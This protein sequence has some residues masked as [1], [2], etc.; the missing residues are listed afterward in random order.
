MALGSRKWDRRFDA[1]VI[2]AVFS[3]T[4]T[5]AWVFWP[6]ASGSR[7]AA[8]RLGKPPLVV[9]CA[10]DSVYSGEILRAFEEQTGIPVEP[11]YDTEA[12]KSL[13][14][15][16][17]IVV[18]RTH[19]RCDVFWNN[20]PLAMMQLRR[21]GLLVPYQGSGHQRIPAKYKDPDG[22]WTGFAARLRVQA[23]SNKFH[24]SSAKFVD[25]TEREDLSR[26]AVAKPLYGTTLMHY[27]LLWKIWGP[28]RLKKWHH[29]IRRRGAREVAGNGPAMDLVASGECDF[30]WT[31]TDD[32]F[33]AHDDGKPVWMQPVQ[34]TVPGKGSGAKP[35][36]VTIC[37]PNTVAIVQ[38]TKQLPEAQRLV[39][40]LLAAE[41]ELSLARSQARQIPLG[42]LDAAKLP[43]DVKGLQRFVDS[44]ADLFELDAARTECLAWLKSEYVR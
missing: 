28:E 14:L 11:R 3:F 29:D 21:E 41:T 19:P 44:G 26:F 20:E 8:D 15:V 12:T 39:D 16:N 27:S 32:Y 1:A 25:L 5:L 35:T 31:D 7:N 22:H 9:Y 4:A 30:C 38:G 43:E 40:F 33:V 6:P 24:P 18:E 42:S 13:S 10:H 37:I 23:V 17:L 36:Q 2:V 34:V